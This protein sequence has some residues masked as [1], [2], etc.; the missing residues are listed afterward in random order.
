MCAQRNH[1]LKVWIWLCCGGRGEEDAARAQAAVLRLV[2][3]LTLTLAGFSKADNTRGNVNI[4]VGSDENFN[5]PRCKETVDFIVKILL[6]NE[7]PEL[8]EWGDED[9]GDSE[10][11]C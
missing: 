7:E 1:I 5:R 4:R 11:D 2:L 8:T 3:L 10:E 9:S 6:D